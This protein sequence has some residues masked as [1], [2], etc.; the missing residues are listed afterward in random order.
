[1]TSSEAMFVCMELLINDVIN[2]VYNTGERDRSV[3]LNRAS[4]AL[5]VDRN[6]IGVFLAKR[7]LSTCS[8]SNG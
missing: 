6:N 7:Q 1:M 3:V 5:F 2:F 8:T 4:S